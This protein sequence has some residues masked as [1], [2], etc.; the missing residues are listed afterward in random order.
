MKCKFGIQ[1]VKD[2]YNK[3]FFYFLFYFQLINYVANL[4]KISEIISLLR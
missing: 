2:V 1:L 3:S 4:Y